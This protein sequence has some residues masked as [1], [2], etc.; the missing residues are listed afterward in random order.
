VRLS[1]LDPVSHLRDPRRKQRYVTALFD[2]IAPGYDRFT[3]L[4][5]FGMDGAWKRRLAAWAVELVPPGGVVL[6]L[7]CGTGDVLE[8]VR[9]TG[10]QAVSLPPRM[11]VGLDPSAAMLAVASRRVA[12]ADRPSAFP[13]VRLLRADMMSLPVADRA[14]AAV[15]VGYGFRNTPDAAAAL[16][17]VARVLEPGGWL[18]DLDF[19]VPEHRGWR[20]LYLW[21]LRVTGRAVG[22]WW[23]GEPEAYGYIARSLEGWLTPVE[24]QALLRGAGFRVE[25]VV[26]YW[27]GGICL[28]AARLAG[29]PPS[30]GMS[31]GAMATSPDP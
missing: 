24:F 11:I 3:R 12:S 17:G 22:R 9:R 16:R 6:D 1:D 7:A 4:F 28:H 31:G 19:F 18:F 8:A 20:R 26:R 2:A 29:R 30:S 23:H 25:R 10:G 13:P 5:S 21:Y 15:T 27:G 14:A